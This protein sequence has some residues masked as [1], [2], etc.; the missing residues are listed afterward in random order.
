MFLSS[1]FEHSLDVVNEGDQL[2]IIYNTHKDRAR[3]TE[4]FSGTG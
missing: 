1:L 4:C 3:A 2:K